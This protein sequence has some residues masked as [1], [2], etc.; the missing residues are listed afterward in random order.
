MGAIMAGGFSVGIY[1]T[2]RNRFDESLFRPDTSS[3]KFLS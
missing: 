3:D 1:T 2:N